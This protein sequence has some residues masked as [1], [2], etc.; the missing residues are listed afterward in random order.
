MDA[1]GV[2]TAVR[3]EEKEESAAFP[4]TPG[5]AALFLLVPLLPTAYCYLTIVMRFV[6][7]GAIGAVAEE[8]AV[9]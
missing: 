7:G 2:L 9:R 1:D 4:G 8:F 5:N 3:R 6:T